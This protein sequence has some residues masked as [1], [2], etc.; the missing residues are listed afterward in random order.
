[1]HSKPNTDTCYCIREKGFIAVHQGRS[2]E[3]ISKSASLRIKGAEYLWDST[4][5]WGFRKV[6][7]GEWTLG[8]DEARGRR[9]PRCF[10]TGATQ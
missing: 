2:R 5:G 6:F 8:K 3:E 1:M 9:K 7:G 10:C 4:R